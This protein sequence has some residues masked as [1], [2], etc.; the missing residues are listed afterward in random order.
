MARPSD[1]VRLVAGYEKLTSKYR[2]GDLEG[3]LSEA[4]KF[5]ENTLRAVEHIRTGVAPPEIKAPL[6]TVKE[7]EKDQKLP[8][9][10]RV[11]IPR[12]AHA[13]VYD[14]RSKRGAIHVKEIDPRNIDAALAVQAS[15]WVLAE[16]LRLFHDSDEKGVTAA[17]NALIR[18][19][20]PWVEQF[21][22]EI[23]VTRKV[24]C[25]VELLMLLARSAPDGMDR[26]HLGQACKYPP[27]RVTEA[28]KRLDG[29][30]HVHRTREGQYHITGS[31]QLRLSEEAGGAVLAETG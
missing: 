24:T 5:V 15:S 22:D 23:V 12:I 28:L 3:C 2:G 18:P 30:R 8:E 6:Q 21:G 19:H 17:L 10:L 26:T 7:I 14:I 9:G 27:P 25:D 20:V 29:A 11:L 13:M 31:G 16:F 1:S 4:G